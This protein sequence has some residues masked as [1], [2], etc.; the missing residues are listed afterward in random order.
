LCKFVLIFAI[1][2]FFSMIVLAQP[3]NLTDRELLI[4]LYTKTESIEKSISKMTDSYRDI[5]SDIVTLDKRVSK[6]E[7]NVADFCTRFEELITRWNA[8]LGLFALFITGMFVWMW[9]KVYSNKKV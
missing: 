2:L 1:I 7:I 5:Q 4:Q 8:L 3:S 6:T 9:K